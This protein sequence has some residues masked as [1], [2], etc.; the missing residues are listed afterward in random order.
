[1]AG[2]LNLNR[3]QTFK[4]ELEKIHYDHLK[5][6]RKS[7]F[8][9]GKLL[10]DSEHIIN[11]TEVRKPGE[12]TKITGHCIRQASVMEYA[13][14][15]RLFLDDDRKVVE[16]TWPNFGCQCGFGEEGLCK[17]FPAFLLHINQDRDEPCTDEAC[18][19][20]E[21]SKA[22]KLKYPKGE[23]LEA[24]VKPK[25]KEKYLC[26]PVAFG[27]VT[28]EAK[29]YHATLMAK[30]GLTNSTMYRFMTLE[31]TTQAPQAIELPDLPQWVKTSVFRPWIHPDIFIKHGPKTARERLYYEEMVD[32]KPERAFW[33][34]GQTIDQAK[35]PMWK[36]RRKRLFTASKVRL[37]TLKIYQKHGSV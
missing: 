26:P 2:N 14:E 4:C 1:M 19:F 25:F 12:L 29:T 15:I 33:M 34:C 18:A 37:H 5:L 9:K 7:S 20:I 13:Y 36:D 35:C 30:H 31:T 3:T 32:M 27:Y 8:V 28:E 11:V 23:E 6:F 21:P 10:L 16:G 22:G 17:H 24:M